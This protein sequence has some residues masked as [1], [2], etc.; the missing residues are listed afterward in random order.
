[1]SNIFI[2]YVYIKTLQFYFNRNKLENS[3]EIYL[4]S[5]VPGEAV[6]SCETCDS[7]TEI[8]CLKK[9][10]KKSKKGY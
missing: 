5:W 6:S 3:V 1:M 4:H 10:H 8:E 2:V 9:R 7:T